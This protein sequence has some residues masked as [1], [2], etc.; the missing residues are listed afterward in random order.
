LK[1]EG[2]KARFALRTVA[3]VWMKWVVILAVVVLG[4]LLWR[5]FAHAAEMPKAGQPAP[6]FSLPDQDGKTRTLAEFRGRWLV[7][8]F[9]P[10]DDTPGCTEQACTFRD[11]WQRL[12]ALGAEVVGVSV[13]DVTSHFSF[14]K[15]YSLPFPLLAD[16]SGEVAGRY[17]SVYRLGPVKFARRNTFLVNP[18]GEVAKVYLSADTSRNSREVIEDIQRLKKP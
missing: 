6:A 2:L 14:A 16:T 9:Y 4:L 7:L 12:S 17:G 15:K 10:K 1:D 8:Y 13:D 18:Q 5:S 11:D 3:E